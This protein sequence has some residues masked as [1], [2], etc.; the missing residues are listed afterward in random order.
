MPFTIPFQLCSKNKDKKSESNSQRLQFNMS[1]CT[2]YR[3]RPPTVRNM[4]AVLK[5]ASWGT[6]RAFRSPPCSKQ[7]SGVQ[8]GYSVPETPFYGTGFHVNRRMPPGVPTEAE[9]RGSGS[10]IGD[11]A[12]NSHLYAP[13]PAAKQLQTAVGC[14]QAAASR[15]QT[16]T[17]PPPNHCKLSW[18]PSNYRQL[19][20]TIA[21]CRVLQPDYR[22]AA[23]TATRLPQTT[24]GGHQ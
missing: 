12:K 7:A 15:H 22:R 21:G 18:T 13:A 8:K 19:R 9:E 16:V 10:E 6:R 17:K 2:P 14:H 23:R 5:K 3:R 11:F 20:Q 4:R 24:P 1:G